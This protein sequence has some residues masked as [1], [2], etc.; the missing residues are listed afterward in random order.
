ARELPCHPQHQGRPRQ[1][2]GREHHRPVRTAALV[3][4]RPGRYPDR[5]SPRGMKPLPALTLLCTL[6]GGPLRAEDDL[7]PTSF[8]VSRYTDIWEDSPFN[9]EVIKVVAQAISSSFA[10]TLTLEGIVTDDTI[11][12]IAYVR[13]NTENQPIVITSAKSDS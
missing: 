5:R 2:Q 6:P 7:L 3:H 11:G 4:S 12:P 13:D 1:R 8:P 10:Q 9:R